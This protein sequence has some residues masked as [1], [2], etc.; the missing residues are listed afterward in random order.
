MMSSATKIM[1]VINNNKGMDNQVS[2]PYGLRNRRMI[3]HKSLAN[4]LNFRTWYVNWIEFCTWVTILSIVQEAYWN[5]MIDDNEIKVDF[6]NPA[7]NRLYLRIKCR[8][9][10]KVNLFYHHCL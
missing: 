7:S 9:N 3:N 1:L 5:L 4:I 2:S 8:K 10:Y 6:I